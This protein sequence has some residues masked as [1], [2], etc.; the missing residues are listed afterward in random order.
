MRPLQPQAVS[1]RRFSPHAL[2]GLIAASCLSLCSMQASAV[3][4]NYDYA[5]IFQGAGSFTLDV[6][7]ASFSTLLSATNVSGSGLAKDPGPNGVWTGVDVLIVD[8][9]VF[10]YSITVET[11]GATVNVANRL[12]VNAASGL[13]AE[14]VWFTFVDQ[15]DEIDFAEPGGTVPA[16]PTLMLLALGLLGLGVRRMRQPGQGH[17]A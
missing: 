6:A 14:E 2:R 3:P 12:G 9:G 10:G 16:P 8:E 13:S 4:I 17:F 7:G 5:N 11:L 1:P 15:R